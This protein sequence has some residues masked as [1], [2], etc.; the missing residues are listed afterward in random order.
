MEKYALLCITYTIL[1]KNMRIF[2]FGYSQC[3]WGGSEYHE[4]F[5]YI[6]HLLASHILFQYHMNSLLSHVCS[7]L[8]QYGEI[9]PGFHYP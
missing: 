1:Y 3:L 7:F 5:V 2:E 6:K 4:I 8:L 9:K